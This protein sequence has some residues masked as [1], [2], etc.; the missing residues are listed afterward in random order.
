M[1]QASRYPEVCILHSLKTINNPFWLTVA[2]WSII[3]FLFHF[4]NKDSQRYWVST[5][6]KVLESANADSTINGIF[7]RFIIHIIHIPPFFKS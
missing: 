6:A 7:C 2:K 4:L 1:Q 3:N 5:L